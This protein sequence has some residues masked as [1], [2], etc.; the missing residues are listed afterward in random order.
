[1]P[2]RWLGGYL[3]LKR[4]WMRTGIACSAVGGSDGS[5]AGW[6]SQRCFLVAHGL[7]GWHPVDFATLI[8]CCLSVL[9]LEEDVTFR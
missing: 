1:M 9:G 8:S 3:A 6:C 4:R 7:G 5:R 2:G